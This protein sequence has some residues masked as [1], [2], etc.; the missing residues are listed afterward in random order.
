MFRII[1]ILV[2][3]LLTAA[4]ALAQREH[5]VYFSG[6]PY[7]L[8]VYKIF[9]HKPGKT[10]MLIGGIQGDEPG[11]F[12]SADSYADMTLET[13]N[14]VVV[15]RANFNS[16][17]LNKRGPNGDMNRKFN[18]TARRDHE[19]KIVTILK[20]L[21]AESDLLLNLHDGS[22]Y[23][24]PR[25]VSAMMNPDRFGQSIIADA[26]DFISPKTGETVRLGDMADQVCLEINRQID[27]P[28]YHFRFNNHRTMAPDTHHPEQRGSAT[29]YALNKVGIP[30][31]G[32]ETS[33]SLPTIEL[34]VRYHNLAIN[35]FMKLMGIIPEHPS[36]KLEKPALRYLVVTVNDGQPFVVDNKKVL[37]L[38][39]GDSIFISH[40]EANYERGLSV[41]ILGLGG[42]NDAREKFVITHPTSVIVRKDHQQCGWIRMTVKEGPVQHAPEINTVAQYFVVAVNGQEKLVASGQVLNLIKG[43]R[44]RLLTTWTSTGQ[45]GVFALNFKGFVSNQSQNTGDD[46]KVV[47]RTDQ[48]LMKKWS[49]HGKGKRYRVVAERGKNEY[50]EFYVRLTDPVID[51]LIVQAGERAKYAV[52]PG[53]TLLLENKSELKVLDAKANFDAKNGLK[54][55]LKTSGNET[56]VALGQ[57]VRE[58]TLK[59]I[60]NREGK[61]TELVAY[62]NNTV[63]GRIFI[64]L[65]PLAADRGEVEKSG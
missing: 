29:Y 59:G 7:E 41:D 32:V 6:T 53:E 16:I 36:I 48:G 30:A 33:K 60:W 42:L 55:I 31:F 57:I 26:R 40:I 61:R 4:P 28:R 9:G 14:L 12:L 20:K 51:Y 21:M 11:G 62:R 37:S 49:I 1:V 17:M 24:R 23:Y 47:I 19:V 54:F 34:K 58:K 45:G 5:I 43:D 38:E 13:G 18:K 56:P 25:Y 46:R 64:A 44:L 39:R 50:G 35:S 63:V 52:S 15:P 8:H 10:L 65:R 3:I 22:G 2:W 27:N